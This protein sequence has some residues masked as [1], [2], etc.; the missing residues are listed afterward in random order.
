MR[1]EQVESRLCDVAAGY[2]ILAS[3]VQG[4]LQPVFGGTCVAMDC[5]L[6]DS[7]VRQDES[8]KSHIIEDDTVFEEAKLAGQDAILQ[9]LVEL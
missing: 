8:T 1:H 2:E 5:H 7:I 3:I 6:I 4:E 9:D